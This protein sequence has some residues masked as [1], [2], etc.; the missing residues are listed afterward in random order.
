MRKSLLLLVLLFSVFFTYAIIAQELGSIKKG[1]AFSFPEK[2]RKLVLDPLPAGTYSVGTGGYFPTID[3]VFNKLSIDGIAGEVTLELTDNLYT[4]PSVQFGFVL[5]GP[6]P[7]A[8]PNSRVIIKP[9][10]NMNVTIQGNNEGLLFLI[11]TSYVTIDGVGLTGATT[12]TI[13]ALQ[14]LSYAFNDALDFINNSDHNIIQNITFIVEDIS[15]ASGSG[16]WYSQT[17]SFAPD[18]NLIQNNFVKMA[19]DPFFIVSPSS[20]VKGKDNIIRGNQ[21]GSETDSLISFGIEVSRCENAIIE[22][23][24]VQNL[25]STLNG[26]DQVLTGILSSMSSGTIIR[27][28]ILGNFKANNG[29]SSSGI[30][31]GGITG[32]NG[33]DNLLYNN[34]IYDIQSTSAQTNSRVTG[35]EVWYQ[36]NTR[37]CYNSVY[38]S[39]SGANMLG[40]AALYIGGT[41]TGVDAKNN[42]LVN[43]RDESPY[44]ASAIYDYTVVNLNSDYDDLFY[45]VSQYSCLVRIGS[46]NY[47]TLA[48]W[49]A[50]GKDLNSIS[51]M[52][53]FIDPY[54][55]IDK[56]ILTNIDAG[57]TPISGIDTDFDGDLRNASTPDIGAD[58]FITIGDTLYVPGDYS[59]I[60]E[61]IDAANNGDVVLVADGLYYENI[62][63]KGKAITVAS[64]FLVDGDSTHI[65]N[66]V[67]DGSQPSHPDSGSVVFFVNGEDA[68]SV[69]C[70][71]TITG[72]TGTVSL[73]WNDRSGGGVYVELSGAT[74]CNNIIEFNSITHNDYTNAGG[75]SIVDS[76]SIIVENNVIRNNSITGDNWSAGGGIAIYDFTQMGYAKVSNNKI[77]NNTV[78]DPNDASGGG[79]EING[80]SNNFFIVGNYIK[81]NE[82]S[83]YG[84]GLDLYD[85]TPNVMNNLIVENSAS[86]GGG[87]VFDAIRSAS[88]KSEISNVNIQSNRYNRLNEKTTRLAK[89]STCS[90]F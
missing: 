33:N 63:Y 62:N 41:S 84:G 90:S 1:Y 31:L 5:N 61:A 4:A 85:C 39:G 82:C 21:I 68:S 64:H 54:L 34:M 87:L 80:G 20:A 76:D 7:G 19:G 46:T 52:P 42:I 32:D 25:K 43:T 2:I 59:T 38:L 14:N 44:C 73:L 72:G 60:Q 23:N 12:L 75:I 66:T 13:H 22:N 35:I 65:E 88:S 45:E 51:E 48:D 16:F 36:D 57:A 11:N 3:S 47:N 79:I 29:Y 67:I 70:G 30:F 8:G 18:S 83:G 50:T 53:N 10:E 81:G 15:R 17:G 86:D 78:T 49:Q 27:N 89:I 28:N 37:I 55:H 71:F 9:A 58:E 40:S 74:I 6:I 77:I 69:L 24:I 26:S 56:T